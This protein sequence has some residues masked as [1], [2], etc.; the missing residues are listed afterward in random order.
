MI[1]QLH[2]YQ[3]K[4][5]QEK[6]Y[7]NDDRLLTNSKSPQQRHRNVNMEY[8][9]V[10]Y[11]FT[12]IIHQRET[13]RLK[14]RKIIKKQLQRIITVC[15]LKQMLTSLLVVKSSITSRNRV[16][17]LENANFMRQW[18]QKWLLEP[19]VSSKRYLKIHHTV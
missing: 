16:K 13:S 8:S 3:N 9:G 19:C 14:K 11:P 10:N 18:M 2:E 7:N 15:R 5:K 1:S 4:N 6:E 17:I 12:Y